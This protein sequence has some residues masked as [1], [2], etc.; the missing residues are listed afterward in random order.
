MKTLL[1]IV[2]TLV[3]LGAGYAGAKIVDAT[4]TKVTGQVP[5]K[6]SDADAQAEAGLRHALTFAVISS[7]V[8]SVIQ[9]MTN[10]GTQRAIARFSKEIA[11]I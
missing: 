3:S 11:E 7:V 8:A 1:K 4:W 5:P 10:R 9:V 2:G 6:V